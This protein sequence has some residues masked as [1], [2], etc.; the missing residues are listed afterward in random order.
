MGKFYPAIDAKV[1]AFN[2]KI[3]RKKCD[4]LIVTNKPNIDLEEF[5]AFEDANAQIYANG[6]ILLNKLSKKCKPSFF[7]YIFGTEN[8]Y[9]KKKAKAIVVDSAITLNNAKDVA[10][11]VIARNLIC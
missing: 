2:E 10:H 1:K 7:E 9:L 8:Y 5:H 3:L 4:D 11:A 6:I